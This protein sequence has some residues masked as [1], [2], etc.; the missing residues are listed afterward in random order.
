MSLTG[1]TFFGHAR[2]RYQIDMDMATEDTDAYANDVTAASGAPFTLLTTSA[3]DSLAHKVVITP[4]GSVTGNYTI[5]GTDA[6]GRAQTEVLAT[7]T[8]SAVTSVKYYLTLTSV[9]AP[10]GLGAETVDIGWAD[11]VAS[12]TI[13]LNDSSGYQAGVMVDHTGT[14]NWTIQVTNQDLSKNTTAPFDFD[15]QEDIFWFADTAFTSKS[16]DTA[17]SLV[18]RGLTAMRVVL[19]SF[20]AGAELQIFVTNPA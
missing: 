10:S 7:N 2:N 13:L 19:N 16:A 6:D 12:Y 20:T 4:S 15:D 1:P 17:A 9:L 5:T 11:E 18:I 14:A 8:T 3:G